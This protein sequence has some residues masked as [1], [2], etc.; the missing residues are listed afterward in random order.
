MAQK[1]VW[2]SGPE[3]CSQADLGELLET[4]EE[5]GVSEGVFLGTDRGDADVL[6]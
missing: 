6:E 1:P 2:T 5:A 3:C 4:W